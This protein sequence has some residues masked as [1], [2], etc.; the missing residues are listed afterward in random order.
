MGRM[1]ELGGLDKMGRTGGISSLKAVVERLI[2]CLDAVIGS[3]WDVVAA[4]GHLEAVTEE[5]I[6]GGQTVRA[7]LMRLLGIV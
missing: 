5:I 1:G 7:K 3:L 2:R 6:L 4:L